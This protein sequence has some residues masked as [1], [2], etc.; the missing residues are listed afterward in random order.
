[1]NNRIF[2]KKE[3]LK[4]ENE[5][6]CLY[7][8]EYSRDGFGF[9]VVYDVDGQQYMYVQTVP[10]YAHRVLPLFDQPNLKATYKMR[11]I[12]LKNWATISTG[13]I[14]SEEDFIPDQNDGYNDLIQTLGVDEEELKFV[15][16]KKTPKLSTYL[17]NLVCGPFHRF[18]LED[19]E[20]VH[21]P[22]SVYCRKSMNSFVESQ[23]NNM[24]KIQQLGVEFYS[25]FF[26]YPYPFD[27]L[28]M[29]LTPELYWGAMEFPG[30]VTYAEKLVPRRENNLID[31][32]GRSKIV[33]HELAHMWFGNL[34][35]MDWWNDLWLNES[36]AE[37]ACYVAFNS[38]GKAFYGEN[39]ERL[40]SYTLFH[41]KILRGYKHDQES[42]THPIA[43]EVKDTEA[44]STIF[45][46][47]TYQK[48]S[49]VMRQLMAILGEE[50]FS[51]ALSR[52]FKKHEYK[53]T[54]LKDLL[55]EVQTVLDERGE[56]LINMQDWNKK[57][58]EEAGYDQI[59]IESIDKT[60]KVMK[61][62][63]RPYNQMY[64]TLKPHIIKFGFYDKDAK[65][66][67]VLDMKL[68]GNPEGEIVDIS[69]IPDFEAVLPNYEDLSFVD[70][71]VDSTSFEFFKENLYRIPETLSRGIL[72]TYFYHRTWES[73][74]SSYDLLDI[75][76]NTLTNETSLILND[77]IMSLV[78]ALVTLICP[79]NEYNNMVKKIY[80]IFLNKIKT[81]KDDEQLETLISQLLQY[82]LFEDQTW[83]FFNWI[84]GDT[85]V[86]GNIQPTIDQTWKI[87]EMAYGFHPGNQELCDSI[88]KIAME[89]DNTDS[90]VKYMIRIEAL[91][92]DDKKRQELLEKYLSGNHS[93]S[94]KELG[95]S[96]DG[97]THKYVSRATKGKTD[98]YLLDN[99]LDSMRKNS[100]TNAKVKF[101]VNFR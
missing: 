90:K 85:E 40:D 84:K 76:S 49:A 64:K 70:F 33:L 35:T 78:L 31:I 53:N 42:T 60:E 22:M 1:M 52:Y 98:A 13:A 47:I 14:I 5:I 73:K 94:T 36:F 63:Q 97:F 95:Y 32:N 18:K 92:A 61:I 74:I 58:I 46:G 72:L 50:G 55:S 66:V 28:D 83:V 30:A 27:K 101:I 29:I 19:P 93:W 48:G 43:G 17:F 59:V 87:L 12:T 81:R 65:L 54:V 45:D 100:Q 15:D 24:F 34:V 10:Y 68:T 2:L 26:G 20:K 44:S 4:S 9:Q 75:L 86:F 56:S 38:V 7:R 16:H 79:Q 99:L 21:L 6:T 91:S 23:I 3:F 51:L 82:S 37:V 67:H 57:W 62:S 39:A 88:K 71:E 80:D 89:R 8:N 96:I 41:T 69:N 77:Y 11:I 25:N